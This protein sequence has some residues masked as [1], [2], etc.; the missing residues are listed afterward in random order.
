MRSTQINLDR[1]KL[2]FSSSHEKFDV[3]PRPQL[4]FGDHL[5]TWPC[6]GGIDVAIFLMTEDVKEGQ[7]HWVCHI[8]S[9]PLII[10]PLPA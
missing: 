8:H 10:F 5:C 1:P 9:T 2:P 4:S 6:A 3:W 7:D